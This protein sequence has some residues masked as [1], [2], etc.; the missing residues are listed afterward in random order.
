VTPPWVM[1]RFSAPGVCLIPLYELRVVRVTRS[2]TLIER[3]EFTT[4][5][6]VWP[7]DRILW[8]RNDAVPR[9]IPGLLEYD[10]S[11]RCRK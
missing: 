9:T 11:R 2:R 6:S 1:Q 8:P 4:P 7:A 10:E 3:E 5:I